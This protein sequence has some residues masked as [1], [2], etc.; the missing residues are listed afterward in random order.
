MDKRKKKPFNETT[1]GKILEKAGSLIPDLAKMIIPGTVDD[2]IIDSI[3]GKTT[4]A[5]AADPNNV[6]L[7]KLLNE[8][9]LAE[10]SMRSEAAQQAHLERMKEMEIAQQETVAVLQDVQGARG[11]EIDYVKLTGK[12]D[13]M[14]GAIGIT[15]L[16]AFLSA[17]VLLFFVEVP[18]TNK[19]IVYSL[20]GSLATLTITI[21]VFYYGSSRG[22][23]VKEQALIRGAK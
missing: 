14:M 2:Q 7:Q 20:V 5:A 11:R 17:L 23:K 8:I 13:W 1:T 21:V 16:V 18:D 9:R 4:D 12:R 3:I 22:S 15:V 10:M 19:D 6:E